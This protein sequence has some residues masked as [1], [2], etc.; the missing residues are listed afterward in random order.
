[1]ISI[2]VYVL[3]SHFTEPSIK[4]DVN[5]L[6]IMEYI[7]LEEKLTVEREQ[8]KQKQEEYKKQNDKLWKM[9]LDMKQNEIKYKNNSRLSLNEQINN[10]KVMEFSKRIDKMNE[11]LEILNQALEIKDH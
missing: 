6:Y 11:Q 4:M 10:P 9:V 8:N 2:I 1:M 5:D 3:Y 7:L